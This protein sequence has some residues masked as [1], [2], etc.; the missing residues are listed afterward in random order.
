MKK[1]NQKA[2]FFCFTHFS[3]TCGKKEDC[4]NQSLINADARIYRSIEEK[5]NP[6]T[7]MDNTVE[8]CA[9]PQKREEL[10]IIETPHALATGRF[11]AV[12]SL[13]LAHQVQIPTG[14]ED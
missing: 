13:K 11:H 12:G 3:K 6:T 9:A 1:K 7:F 5:T 4:Y 14:L 2:P 10:E 8:L